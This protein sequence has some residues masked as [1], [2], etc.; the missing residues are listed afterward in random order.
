M[1]STHIHA[2]SQN[3]VKEADLNC[4]RLWLVSYD[5]P[6]T[7]HSLSQA[8]TWVPVTLW[9]N[10]TL[11][12]RLPWL[13]RVCTVVGGMEASLDL[14]WEPD[15]ARGAITI[16]CVGSRSGAIRN[17]CAGTVLPCVLAHTVC[18]STAPF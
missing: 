10:S 2:C 3:K 6:S 1:K 18:S 17:W 13:R 16:A 11:Q 8:P 5:H 7:C 9:Q 12:Q 15:G 4:P 14:E